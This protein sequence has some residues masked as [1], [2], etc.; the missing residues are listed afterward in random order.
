MRTDLNTGFA[1]RPLAVTSTVAVRGPAWK[2][3]LP[4]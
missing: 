1:M 4:M 3:L 2:S